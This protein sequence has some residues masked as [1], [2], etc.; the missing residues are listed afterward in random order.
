MIL[1]EPL[2]ESCILFLQGIQ[3]KFMME[4]NNCAPRSPPAP[5]KQAYTAPNGM[6]DIM[7]RKADVSLLIIK[8]S[9][10]NNSE[11][12]NNLACLYHW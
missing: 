3:K 5:K 9:L 12:F 6:G 7:D 10:L 2:N 8:Q 11:I 1:N 4:G